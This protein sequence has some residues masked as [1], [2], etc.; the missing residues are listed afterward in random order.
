MEAMIQKGVDPITTQ[1]IRNALVSAAEEMRIALV[2]TAYNPLI[3]EVQDFAVALLTKKGEI[4]AQGASLPLF[5]AC[6]PTTV[7]NGLKKFGSDGFRPGDIIIANDPYTTGT[8][9]SDTAIYC[10]IFFNG[11][12]QAFSVNMAH[13][14]D[15]GG[16]SLEAG[17][18]TRPMFIRRGC[19]FRIS[20][21]M[22]RTSST[23]LS[24]TTSLP[25]LVSPIWSKGI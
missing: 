12:L 22:R 7:E 4:L 21:C 10:P 23:K 16:K 20:S 24:W 13:W 14:A 3:Y 1:V 17:V 9:I 18:P 11:T 6:F 2:K 19:S 5:L 15:I 25:I 8:H